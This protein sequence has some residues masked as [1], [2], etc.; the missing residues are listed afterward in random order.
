MIKLYID[1]RREA[2][3]GWHQC[4]DILE[5]YDFVCENAANISHIDFD[6]YLSEDMPARTGELLIR[7]FIHLKHDGIT[8]FHQ[9]IENY[10]FHSS[11]TSMNDRMRELVE[12]EFGLIKD[13]TPEKPHRSRLARMRESRGRR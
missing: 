7:D 4:W 9:P 5:A 12:R 6:Y 11:D 13:E 2:P 8:V 10:T 3:E 1:D